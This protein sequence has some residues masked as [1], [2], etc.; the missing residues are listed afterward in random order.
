MCI[1]EGL[2][3]FADILKCSSAAPGHFCMRNLSQ[4]RRHGE[5]RGKERPWNHVEQII[6]SARVPQQ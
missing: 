2:G 1:V 3:Q 6:K 4:Q 5:E